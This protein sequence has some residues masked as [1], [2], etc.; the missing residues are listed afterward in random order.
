M[1]VLRWKLFVVGPKVNV[2]EMRAD[3]TDHKIAI[4]KEGEPFQD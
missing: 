1:A 3:F 2:P 4:H